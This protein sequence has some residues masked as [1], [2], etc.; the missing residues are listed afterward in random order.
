MRD[1]YIGDD[2]HSFSR[3]MGKYREL[4]NNVSSQYGDGKKAL[5][6]GDLRLQRGDRTL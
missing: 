1:I 6:L 2:L 4:N 5:S 3:G